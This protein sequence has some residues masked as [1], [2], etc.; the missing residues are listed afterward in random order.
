MAWGRGWFLS[1][2]TF[3]IWQV[4][5]GFVERHVFSSKPPPPPALSAADAA[6]AERAEKALRRGMRRDRGLLMISARFTY[7]LGEVYL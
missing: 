2:T 5:A 1:R 3:L 6:I 7:D 4:P